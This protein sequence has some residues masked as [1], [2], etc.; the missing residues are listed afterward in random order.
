MPDVTQLIV[1]K[2][3]LEHNGYQSQTLNSTTQRGA[4]STRISSSEPADSFWVGAETGSK[5]VLDKESC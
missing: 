4:K 1:A 5:A 3:G 2:P